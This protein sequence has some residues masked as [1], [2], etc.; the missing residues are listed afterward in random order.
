MYRRQNH[1]PRGCGGAAAALGEFARAGA[2]RAGVCLDYAA[3][4]PSYVMTG[5]IVPLGVGHLLRVLEKG[6]ISGT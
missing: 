4:L 6:G 1:L 2:L 5:R 3:L